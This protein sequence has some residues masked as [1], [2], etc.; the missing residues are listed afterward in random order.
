MIRA[1]NVLFALMGIALALQGPA[2]AEKKYD[3]G[4]SDT[5]IK[6]GQTCPTAGQL[7]RLAPW[8]GPRPLTSKK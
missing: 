8:G 4:A 2:R 7:P 1:R 3:T 5:E 6:L